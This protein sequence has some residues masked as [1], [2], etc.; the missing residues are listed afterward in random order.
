[1]DKR[2]IN[3]IQNE[4][5]SNAIIVGAPKSGKTSFI[6]LL[7]DKSQFPTQ[8]KEETS[9]SYKIRNFIFWDFKY[10]EIMK[11]YLGIK[12]QYSI[13]VN[14]FNL[15]HNDMNI[16]NETLKYTDYWIKD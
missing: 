6:K 2:F 3:W 12:C 13:V 14:L 10:Q 9:I 8:I 15:I 4:I 11:L 1:M 7:K 16:R 5:M